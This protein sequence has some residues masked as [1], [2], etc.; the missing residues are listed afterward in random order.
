MVYRNRFNFFCSLGYEFFDLFCAT[1]PQVSLSVFQVTF[2][3]DL[4]DERTYSERH[5]EVSS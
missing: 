1:I 4:F 5:L 3:G 2:C